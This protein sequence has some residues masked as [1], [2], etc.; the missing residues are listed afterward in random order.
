VHPVK[1]QSRRDAEFL[2][3]NPDPVDVTHELDEDDAQIHRELFGTSQSQDS[4]QHPLP[5]NHILDTTGSTE[6][7]ADTDQSPV[8]ISSTNAIADSPK[9][10]TEGEIN[11]GGTP[12]IDVGPVQH[13]ANAWTAPSFLRPSSIV[14]TVTRSSCSADLAPHA[15]G[16]SKAANANQSLKAFLRRDGSFNSS[17]SPR[18]DQNQDPAAPCMPLEPKKPAQAQIKDLLPSVI[19]S[20]QS[21]PNKRRKDVSSDQDSIMESRTKKRRVEQAG[22]GSAVQKMAHVQSSALIAPK[23]E[24]RKLKGFYANLNGIEM[25]KK[26][27][28]PVVTWPLLANILLDVSRDRDMEIQL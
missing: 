11:R 13:D 15:L 20:L 10:I 3:A 19:A 24:R 5:K 16:E 25:D 9:P 23:N 7:H 8:T 18:V 12:E 2:P 27:V 22:N 21:R 1:S 28:L 6:T 14:K 4:P 17:R 26:N